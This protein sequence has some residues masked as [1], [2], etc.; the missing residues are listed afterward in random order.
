MPFALAAPLIGMGISALS[1]LFGGK[2]QNEINTTQNTSQ[3]FN[4][5]NTST[6]TPNLNPFQQQL[7][8]LFTQ[9]A[10]DQYKQ[11]TNLAPYTSQ[12]LQQIAGQGAANN[13][14]ISNILAQRGLSY[15]PAAATGLTQNAINTGGQMTSFLS[16]IP[17]LRR[18][19]ERGNLDQLMKAFAVQ[20]IGS[21]TSGT[22]SGESSG[23]S[24]GVNTQSGNPTAG[25]FGGLGA[26]MFAPNSGS[27]NLSSIIDSIWGKKP[28]SLPGNQY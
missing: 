19:L 8:Q 9:G 3:K 27:S 6:N 4:T 23:T 16:G 22:S 20:P 1:G 24:T 25:F 7:S 18:E 12:G 21:T 17:L 10:I 5:T 13:K 28:G 15:S 26:G 11:G 2:K 14:I